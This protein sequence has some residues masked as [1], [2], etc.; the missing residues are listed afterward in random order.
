MLDACEKGALCGAE[1][2]ARQV[3]QPSPSQPGPIDYLKN[4]VE[5]IYAAPRRKTQMNGRTGRG[6]WREAMG[7]VSFCAS[8]GLAHR[9]EGRR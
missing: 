8:G 5:I 6:L 2:A 4:R 1:P 7:G 3:K 9:R